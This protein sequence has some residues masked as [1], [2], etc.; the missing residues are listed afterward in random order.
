MLTFTQHTYLEN[1]FNGQEERRI[2]LSAFQ[3]FSSP[4]VTTIH[5]ACG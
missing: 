4:E 5:N 1:R 2:T 3:L